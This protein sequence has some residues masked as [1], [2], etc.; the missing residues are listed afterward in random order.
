GGAHAL[1][2]TIHCVR[3]G[4]PP[5]HICLHDNSE[6]NGVALGI[7][8]EQ[9][10]AGQ[11]EKLQPAIEAR[12]R[13]NRPGPADM[14]SRPLPCPAV[15]RGQMLTELGHIGVLRGIDA[16]KRHAAQNQNDDDQKN[17]EKR[18]HGYSSVFSSFTPEPTATATMT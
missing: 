16:V 11:V 8:R 17:D 12:H 2:K 15:M 1:D 14:Q 7:V 13:L 18:S 3:A 6:S 9:L 4:N 5:A 10:R